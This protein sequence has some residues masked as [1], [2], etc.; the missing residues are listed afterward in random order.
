[1]KKKQFEKYLVVLTI[2]WSILPSLTFQLYDG[3][4]WTQQ[5]WMFVV[6][7]FG[8]YIR[9]YQIDYKKTHR[10]SFFAILFMLALLAS[11]VTIDIIGEYSV[12]L[13]GKATYFGWSNSIIAFPLSLFVF[14]A[15][16]KLKVIDRKYIKFMGSSSFAIYLLH[17]NT[18]FS[19]FLWS[20]CQPWH[21]YKLIVN[22]FLIMFGVYLLG[23][24]SYLVWRNIDRKMSGFYLLTENFFN[25]IVEYIWPD[26]N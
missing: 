15:F 12:L 18:W 16:L 2:L 26:S 21:S 10:Y 11:V 17:E 22:S 13:S 23:L 1:M 5:I 24:V 25:R 7:A 20:F 19:G 3:L 6:W 14:M 8:F 4:N 9:K